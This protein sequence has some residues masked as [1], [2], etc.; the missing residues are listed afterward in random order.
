MK[1]R[2]T[3]R[4]SP[5]RVRPAGQAERLGLT[6]HALTAEEKQQ[7]QTDGTLVVET[8][9]GPAAAAGM[10]PG[11]IILGVN[12]KPVHSTADLLAASKSASKTIALLI[13][14][15]DQQIFM[16]LRLN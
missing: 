12:G 6:V 1:T 8:V 10:Q 7:A 5:P 2:R 3:P 9:A 11:D 16:P 13:Q 15:Q 4:P 14:R